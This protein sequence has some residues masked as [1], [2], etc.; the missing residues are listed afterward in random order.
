MKGRIRLLLAKIVRI[1]DG[2]SGILQELIDLLIVV[3][4]E[5]LKIIKY[6]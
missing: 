2:R 5:E 1:V 3:F 4:E 6:R